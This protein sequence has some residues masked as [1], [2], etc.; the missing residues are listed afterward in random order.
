MTFAWPQ[1]R[2]HH[3]ERHRTPALVS[4]VL[5]SPATALD[6][7]T[8]AFFEPRFGHDFGR[9]R[10]H[11]DAEAAA[12]ARAVNASAY[13]VGQHIAFDS[14]QF[15]PHTRAG[16]RLLAHELAHT[17]QQKQATTAIDRLSIG[18]P[19]DAFEKEADRAA[20]QTFSGGPVSVQFNGP[21]SLQRQVKPDSSPAADMPPSLDVGLAESASPFMAAAIGSVT[22]D[23]F[24]TGKSDI[25]AENEKQL[26]HTAET[27]LTLLK[28]YPAA[29]ISVTGH[30]DAV[31]QE[32]DNQSLGQARADATMASLVSHGVTAAIM[33]PISR[34]E[35]ELLVKT[36]KAEPKNRRAEVRF[37]P[38]PQLP[39]IMSPGPSSTITPNSTQTPSVIP[40][41]RKI[42]PNTRTCIET[43]DLCP[44]G[45][46]GPRNPQA[47]PMTSLPS[48]IPYE[49][50]DVAGIND[51][52]TSH[53]RTPD[54][55]LRETWGK[56]WSKYFYQ[57]HLSREMAAKAANSEMSGTAGA[58]QSRDNP[59]KVDDTNND[60]KKGYPN[61]TGVGPFNLP[62]KYHF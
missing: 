16:Q 17:V 23:H 58:D 40:D 49:L 3:L 11:S 31:G 54:S 52:Y 24:V 33:T 2:G 21:L 44:Q 57:W 28:K 13:T 35:S 20:S 14:G 48:N 41:L 38:G 10:V 25:S 59:N 46:G 45:W 9:V 6:S 22:I 42:G 53:G 4:R 27:I 34:G 37:H 30:T 61:S 29:T 62:W 56:M 19:S 8:R 50:M 55:G 5:K 12:S 1:R 32:S 60:M 15:Q 36:K 18:A 7:K 47:P 51:A 39:H 26:A 43:P